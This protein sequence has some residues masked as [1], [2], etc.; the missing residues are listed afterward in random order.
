MDSQTLQRLEMDIQR[1]SLYEQGWLLERL[2]HYIRT[3]AARQQQWIES[4]LT[5]M[6]ADPDIR[7]EIDQ[8]QTEFS[9]TEL[10]GL[11]D[12]P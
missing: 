7:R 10:D 5:A 4:Q 3:G 12:I 2:A 1:L 6:A 9:D 11:T 8:I